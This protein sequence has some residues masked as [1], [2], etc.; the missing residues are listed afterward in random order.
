VRPVWIV[1][2]FWQL[3]LAGDAASVRALLAPDSRLYAN[4]RIV[5][6][7]RDAFLARLLA[8]REAFPERT[9]RIHERVAVGRRVLE[10][11]TLEARIAGRDGEAPRVVRIHG[12]S[13]TLC[14]DDRVAEVH[15]WWD[16]LAVMRQLTDAPPLA[17]PIPAAFERPGAR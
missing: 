2:R 16:P 3:T 12:A 6:D 13:W 15:Q 5:L 8:I 14:Q 1:D 7:G 10:R 9:V 11:W 17:P 4:D